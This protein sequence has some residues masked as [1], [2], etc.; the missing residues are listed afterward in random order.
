MNN[1][2]ELGAPAGVPLDQLVS[3]SFQDGTPDVKRGAKEVFWCVIR[4][5]SGRL[6]H[7]P[8]TYCNAHVMPCS[9]QCEPSDNAVPVG[10]D[11]DYEWTGWFEQSCEY[12]DTQWAFTFEV[13]AWMRL[14]RFNANTKLSNA[15]RAERNRER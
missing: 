5:Q 7:R 13:V 2:P 9:D 4:S 6:Y 1:T 14:P 12:C 11:G 3:V 15:P 10:D 8:L